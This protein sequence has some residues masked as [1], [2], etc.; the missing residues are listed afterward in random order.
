MGTKISVLKREGKLSY[1]I[2]V[3]TDKGSFVIPV[4]DVRDG[5]SERGFV[6]NTIKQSNVQNGSRFLRPSYSVRGL[7]Y[8]NSYKP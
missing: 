3:E 5:E 2:K 4:I 8:Q 1:G 7:S 6:A